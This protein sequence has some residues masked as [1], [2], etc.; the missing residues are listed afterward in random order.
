MEEH[1]SNLRSELGPFAILPR[2]I[3]DT[4]ISHGAVRLYC[5][6]AT[7]TNESQVAWPSRA[8]LAKRLDASTKS[9]NRYLTELD[10][11]GA[12]QIEHRFTETQSGNRINKTNLYTLKVVPPKTVEPLGVVPPMGL[13]SDKV[14]PTGSVM[15]VTQNYNQIELEPMNKQN[16]R[17]EEFWKVY[18]RPQNKKTAKEQWSKKIKCP[19]L[20]EQVIEA[21]TRQAASTEQKYIPHAYKWLR[22]ERWTDEVLALKGTNMTLDRMQQY[23][24]ERGLVDE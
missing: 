7:Y 15:D 8:T 24:I 17:F 12:V 13:P 23:S 18:K 6:L 9:V 3:L 16:D 5:V 10:K 14:D 19:Q 11:I 21:A 4:E 22:D 1:N 2:W 20:A